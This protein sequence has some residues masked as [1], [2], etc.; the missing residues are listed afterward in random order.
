MTQ[1]GGA[2]TARAVEL[3]ASGGVNLAG[4]IQA[5]DALTV[6]ALGGAVVQTGTATTG[7]MTRYTAAGAIVLDG[8]AIVSGG[9]INLVSQ[10][11]PLQIITPVGAPTAFT[12]LTT[13][14]VT[15]LTAANG[16]IMIGETPFVSAVNGFLAGHSGADLN[17][18]RG[19]PA[20]AQPAALGRVFVQTGTLHLTASGGVVQQNT[21]P[22]PGESAG[23]VITNPV[24][25]AAAVLISG[26]GGKA[27]SVVDL[28][29]TLVNSGGATLT[30]KV[31]ATSGEVDL[32]ITPT[33]NYRVNG[34]VIGQAGVCTV[35]SD[36]IVDVQP[37]NLT[38]DLRLE[39]LPNASISDP[40][41][42]GTGNEEIWRHGL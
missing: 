35:L 10:S 24:R 7:G 15:S 26:A 18:S 37:A 3:S 14:G 40:T 19:V 16:S 6:S 38:G 30:G 36:A 5:G 27:P 2:I 34:C 39:S 11:G 25:S 42:T 33:N 8:G 9:D 17:V 1:T 29:L 31:V 20:V 28:F 21:T 4:L 32:A 22:F 23:M 41:I 13:P 12:N